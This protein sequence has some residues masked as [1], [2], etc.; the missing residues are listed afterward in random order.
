MKIVMRKL[1]YYGGLVGSTRGTL[2][3]GYLPYLQTVC[4]SQKDSGSSAKHGNYVDLEY[5]LLF[6]VK[7]PA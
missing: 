6:E 5:I 4:K 7:I 1:N 3:C 2:V